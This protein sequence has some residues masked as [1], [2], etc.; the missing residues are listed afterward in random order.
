MVYLRFLPYFLV[1]K[2]FNKNNIKLSYSCMLNVNNI[3][4]KHSSKIMKNLAPSTTK[5]CNCRRKTE[6]PMHD[7]C[8]SE[9]LMYE[10]FVSKTTDT[11][12]CGPCTNTLKEPYNNHK[13]SFRN[14]SREKN[15]EF[16][17]H[18]W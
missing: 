18:V 12:Y 17:K 9:C 14:K 3:I 11:Y 13:S 6:C 4:R 7:N 2:L 16:S 5:N 10:A 15:T 8:L 1:N